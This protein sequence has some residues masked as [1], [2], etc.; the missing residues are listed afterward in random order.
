MNK[1]I[2][3]GIIF[4]VIVISPVYGALT[5]GLVAYYPLNESSGT[6]TYDTSG[7]YNM[8]SSISIVSNPGIIGN[9]HTYSSNYETISTNALDLNTTTISMWIYPYETWTYGSSPAGTRVIYSNYQYGMIYWF[10]KAL[11]CAIKDDPGG[12]WHTTAATMSFSANT[13]YHIVCTFGVN[14]SITLYVNSVNNYSSSGLSSFFSGSNYNPFLGADYNGATPYQGRIDEFG[15]WNR[16]LTSGEIS[17]LYNNGIG[18]SVVAFAF[19]NVNCTSIPS[20]DTISPYSTNT[21]RP[22]FTFNTT[23]L[24]SCRISHTLMTYGAMGDSRN[25]TSGQ[26]TT[27]HTCTLTAQDALTTLTDYA[28]ITCINPLSDEFTVSLLMDVSSL[29]N[30]FTN[31]NC[32][33]IPSGDMIAPYT[34]NTTTPTF[35]FNTSGNSNCRISNTNASYSAMTSSRDCTSGQSATYHTCVLTAQDALI[36]TSD[37]VYIS[38]SYVYNTSETSILLPMDVLPNA[39]N[40]TNVNCTSAGP[41]GDITAPYSTYDTTPTFNFTTTSN[42][43]CRISDESLTYNA[44]TNSTDCKYGQNTTSHVCTLTIPDELVN[45]TDY[46]YISCQKPG[47]ETIVSLLMDITYLDTNDSRSIDYGI[48]GSTIWP[49]ATIYSNQ[50]VYLRALNGSNVTATVDKVA[51]YGNQRWIIHYENESE[52]KIGLFNLTPVVYVL[53]MKN[54]S[55]SQIRTTVSAFINGTKI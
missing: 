23:D 40:I 16:T 53:E 15:I 52:P 31:V 20:G 6:L 10:N 14:Q 45:A 27:Y 48:M 38:C 9:A 25:C 5:D 50:K 3:L 34:T 44:M 33:S 24:A 13:W 30:N 43:S 4:F 41:M 32:T 18:Y 35:S 55:L 47:N 46:V 29:T 26:N 28:Y 17:T 8:T 37:Y 39:N 21:T 12:V 1:G 11:Q 42:S 22:T 36:N 51:V 49:G 19:N 2:I 54:I 7:R